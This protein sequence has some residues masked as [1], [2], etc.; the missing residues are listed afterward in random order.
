[1]HWLQQR[2]R[3][4]LS[5]FEAIFCAVLEPNRMVRKIPGKILILTSKIAK[6]TQNPFLQRMALRNGLCA[7]RMATRDSSTN[8]PK[9]FIEDLS[10]IFENR[11]VQS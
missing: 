11:R 1:V 10:K 9:R 3:S 6:F 5:R 2:K 4:I 7:V 8:F